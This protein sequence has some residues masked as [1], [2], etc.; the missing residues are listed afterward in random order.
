MSYI[1]EALKKSERERGQGEVPGVQTVHSAGLLYRQP[2]KARWPYFLIAAIGLNAVLL[3]A[4]LYQR[5]STPQTPDTRLAPAAGDAAMWHENIAP[6]PASLQEA[7]PSRPAPPARHALVREKTPPPGA[8]PAAPLGTT[9][10]PIEKTD[11]APV[12]K[13]ARPTAARMPAAQP[14]S[15]PAD[16]RATKPP[17]QDATPA[18][19][20]EQAH[21]A[22]PQDSAMQNTAIIDQNEL[23]PAIARQLPGI[24]ISAHIYS[25]TPAQRSMIINNRYLEEGDFVDEGL[26]LKEITPQGAIFDYNGILFRNNEVAGWQ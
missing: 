26:Q 17:G 22:A 25:A 1:L 16:T 11:A 21:L 20:A 8:V 13:S 7:T 15:P 3:A 14:A 12:K 5:Q 23:P 6:A 9:Q 4:F 18:K 24:V 2:A 19:H 10:A